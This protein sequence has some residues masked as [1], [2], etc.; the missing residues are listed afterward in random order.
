MTTGQAEMRFFVGD[1]MLGSQRFG[2]QIVGFA[3]TGNNYDNANNV[4]DEPRWGDYVTSYGGGVAI[5][6]NLN[7]IIHVLAGFSKEDMG[8]SINFNHRF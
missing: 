5:P 1:T 6:W 4:Y 2:L 8:I 3:D 7:T